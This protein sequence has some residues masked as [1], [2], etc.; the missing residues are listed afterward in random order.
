MSK[1]K[2]ITASYSFTHNYKFSTFK[3]EGSVTLE[4]EPGDD[5]EKVTKDAYN[6][7]LKDV[8]MRAKV[9]IPQFE[10]EVDKTK[11]REKGGGQNGRK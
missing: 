3:L 9:L 1:V 2:E 4:L 5:T 7:V 6:K 8:T 11:E 10:A